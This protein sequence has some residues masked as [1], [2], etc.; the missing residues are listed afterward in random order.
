MTALK[1]I[2]DVKKEIDDLWIAIDRLA[3]AVATNTKIIER[4]LKEES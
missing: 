4:L 2:Q 3:D 1:D